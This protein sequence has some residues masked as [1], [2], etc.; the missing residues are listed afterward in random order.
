MKNLSKKPSGQAFSKMMLTML[1]LYFLLCMIV[2]PQRFIQSSLN[3]ISAWAFNVL[4]SVLPFMFFTRLLSSLGT[5]ENITKPFSKL[6]YKLFKTPSISIYVFLMAILSGYP[7]GTKMVADQYLQGK[8]SKEDA[9]KMTS[10]CSTSGPM[11]IVGAV[12]ISMFK[13]AKIGYILLLSHILSSIINGMVFSKIKVKNEEKLQKINIRK[14]NFN[15][16]DIVLDSTISIL[17]VG[18]IITIFF[19]I[20]E[21]FA[22]VFNFLPPNISAFFQGVIEITKGCLTLSQI[23]NKF[24][25]VSLASFV[26]SFGGISTIIQAKTM[27]KN[28]NMP[29]SLFVL[30][31]LLHGLISFA[32]TAIILFL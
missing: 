26:I 19:I 16:S 25:A 4:P 13:S 27:L 11:F 14:Q 23:P 28:L 17:S 15:I 12:G 21:C 2:F 9:L 3:G 32:I 6:S 1:C 10:F 5:M 31:K 7:V 30:Q 18:C 20:I 29:T 22:P 24:L 8:I